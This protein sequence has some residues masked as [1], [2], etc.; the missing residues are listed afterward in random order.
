MRPK[1][2][3]YKKGDKRNRKPGLLD[4][5]VLSAAVGVIHKEIKPKKES[6]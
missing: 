6:K 3:Q 1:K 4:C 2:R 5:M